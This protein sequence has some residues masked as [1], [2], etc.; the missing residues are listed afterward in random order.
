MS[1]EDG[2]VCVVAWIL[3]LL[4]IFIACVVIL[5]MVHQLETAT[6]RSHDSFMFFCHHN[7]SNTD[8][9]LRRLDDKF[10]KIL[11]QII[12]QEIKEKNELEEKWL[13]AHIIIESMLS[14]LKLLKSGKLTTGLR[15]FIMP[16][17]LIDYANREFDFEE[18][19]VVALH[20]EKFNYTKEEADLLRRTLPH[21]YEPLIIMQHTIEWKIKSNLRDLI[22]YTCSKYR[23]VTD[24]Q[25]KIVIDNCFYYS[26]FIYKFID[27]NED[28]IMKAI[29][30][31]KITSADRLESFVYGLFMDQI[32]DP[33]KVMRTK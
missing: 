12:P 23:F 7:D 1:R 14:Q 28:G 4:G 10:D 9:Y 32:E 16:Y 27:L 26:E 18:D 11:E 33:K 6:C 17:I 31:G 21:R 30:S 29:S 3:K 5:A 13:K 2:S 25:E 19:V 24:Q 15:A 22:R 8:I 20:V